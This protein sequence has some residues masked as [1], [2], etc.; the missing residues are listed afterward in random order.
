MN[1]TSMNRFRNLKKRGG[2]GQEDGL[3]ESYLDRI[4]GNLQKKHTAVLKKQVQENVIILNKKERESGPL[5]SIK[6][7][8]TEAEDLAAVKEENSEDT[9]NIQNLIQSLTDTIK[10]IEKVKKENESKITALQE[11]QAEEI[12]QLE[13]IQNLGEQTS[14]AQKKA[15]LSKMLDLDN[16]SIEELKEIAEQDNESLLTVSQS[17]LSFLE[18][19]AK[20]AGVDLL[21][22]RRQPEW[23]ILKKNIDILEI[24]TKVDKKMA[25][26][27]KYLDYVD[28]LPKYL[29]SDK[30]DMNTF[31]DLYKIFKVGVRLD[32]IIPE[33]GDRI[34]KTLKQ[35]LKTAMVGVG[36]N[37]YH[38]YRI[39]RH[40]KDYLDSNPELV[41][42]ALAEGD[43]KDYLDSNPELVAQASGRGGSKRRRRPKRTKKRKTSKKKKKTN[44][45]KKRS[46]K[47][48]RR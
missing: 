3:G 4:K 32:K 41:A 11:Q 48:K 8:K 31:N 36:V 7:D 22:L 40:G 1:K 15:E 5:A 2:S 14:P 42:Q 30:R 37:L 24:K 35:T 19:E 44:K 47:R 45:K 38:A 29:G 46:T 26:L 16:L 6:K 9:R 43:G 39:L 20:K 13:R 27:G 23:D 18:K 25:A 12:E 28:H 34:D 21:V 33:T 10:E 17:D